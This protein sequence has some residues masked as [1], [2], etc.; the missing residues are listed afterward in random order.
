MDMPPINFSA[1]IYQVNVTLLLSVITI[2]LT[3]MGVLTKVFGRKK[4]EEPGEHPK[5]I[6]HDERSKK[7]EADA[8]ELREKVENMRTEVSVMSV[9]LENNGKSVEEL[10]HDS[11][12]L[13]DKMDDL[14]SQML[15]FLD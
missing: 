15:D 13:A 10:K 8:K 11:R 14:L 12:K 6:S 9:K 7:N 5:C 4:E 3:G 2:C 1:P